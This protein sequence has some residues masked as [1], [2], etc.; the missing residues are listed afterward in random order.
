MI[1]KFRLLIF[2]IKDNFKRQKLIY[3]KAIEDPENRD[4]GKNKAKKTEIS[5]AIFCVERQSQK[6]PLF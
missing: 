6:T 3:R 1:L 5:L 2:R 4:G